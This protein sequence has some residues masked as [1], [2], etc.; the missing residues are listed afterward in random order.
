M[1]YMNFPS[2]SADI[3]AAEII[4]CLV[5]LVTFA[6]QMYPVVCF[7]EAVVMYFQ[8]GIASSADSSS[9]SDEESGPKLK[10]CPAVVLRWGLVLLAS[11][12]A[13]LV[14]SAPDMMNFSGN[15]A[16]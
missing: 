1:F 15:F 8:N 16:M 5:L 6:L 7:A 10:G 3:K 11:L 4:L 12:T 2:G 13:L 14:P 9:S